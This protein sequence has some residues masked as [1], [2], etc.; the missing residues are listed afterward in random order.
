MATTTLQSVGKA[1]ILRNEMTPENIN[2]ESKSGEEDKLKTVLRT[3][4]IGIVV[5]ALFGLM[6]DAF[7]GFYVLRH[8]KSIYTGCAGIFLLSLFYLIGEAGSTWISS[9]DK[10]THPWYK[11]LFHLFM[12]L[13]YA[14]L[15]ILAAGIAFNY[16]KIL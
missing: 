8:S 16:L 10:V 2:T 15:I 9:K 13:V 3:I 7:G 6:L 1:V 14:A 4:T 11:R 12:L 5:L